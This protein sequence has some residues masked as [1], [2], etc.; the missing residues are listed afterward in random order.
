MKS[1][2]SKTL[3]KEAEALK[4]ELFNLKLE[5]LSGQVKDISQFRKL[6]V[7]IAQTLTYAKKKNLDEKNK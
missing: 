4:K 7:K 1:L 3:L 6:R 2:D 5:I